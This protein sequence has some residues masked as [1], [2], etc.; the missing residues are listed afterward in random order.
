M[1]ID[2]FVWEFLLGMP[3]V[4]CRTLQE[5]ICP[6]ARVSETETSEYPLKTLLFTCKLIFIVMDIAY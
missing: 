4:L 1:D 3:N 2:S 5:S 6:E